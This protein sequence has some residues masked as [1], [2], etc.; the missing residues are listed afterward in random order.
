MRILVTGSRS[1]LAQELLPCLHR[2]GFTVI[3]RA[4]PG[5]DLTRPASIRAAFQEVQPMLCI[6]TAAYTAVDRAESEVD[7][8]FAVNRDGVAHLAEVCREAG[9]PLIHLSTDY[10]FAGTASH[11]YREED[12]TAP[13]GVYG[14]SKWEGEQA[15]RAT[16]RDHL[17]VRTAWLYGYHGSNFVKTMLRLAHERHIVHVVHDQHGCPTWTRDLAQALTAMCQQCFQGLETFPWGTYHF[18]AAGQTTWYD[19]ARAIFAAYPFAAA[20]RLERVEPISTAAYAAPAQRPA[21]SV[22]D[23]AK[24]QATFGITPRS[25]RTSLHDCLREWT[26]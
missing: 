2:A 19:F 23:V 22:L 4:R 6:N 26:P 8:A 17:I 18:C 16:L 7:A 10:V 9:V 21:Y 24:F 14:R 1:M 3:G 20:L 13:L 11:P 12:P 15:V 5:L 25:W